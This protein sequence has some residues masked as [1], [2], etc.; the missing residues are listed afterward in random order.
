MFSRANRVSENSVA[1]HVYLSMPTKKKDIIQ[2]LEQPYPAFLEQLHADPGTAIAEFERCARA[3]LSAHPSASMRSLTAAEQQDV[4]DETI[5]RCKAK[6]G[7]PLRNYS[8][9]WGSF[10]TWL[11]S[12]AESTCNS[13]FPKRTPRPEA[14]P[15]EEGR[16]A[17]PGAGTGDGS[18]RT[19]PAPPAEKKPPAASPPRGSSP[20]PERPGPTQNTVFAWLRSPR[21]LILITIVAVIVAFRALQSSRDTSPGT[22][23]TTGPIDIALLGDPESRAPQY[24]VLELNN[25]TAAEFDQGR[26]PVTAV[27]RSGRLT[28]LR[29]A[30]GDLPES[31]SPSRLVVEN[32]AG[33]IA[34]DAPIDPESF[35]GGALN[36]RIDPKT[37]VPDEYVIRVLG[38]SDAILLRSAFSIVV[39]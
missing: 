29:L 13:K 20:S 22:S 4:I 36:L 38:T 32:K 28:V 24:D 21:V 16:S 15:S 14:P 11:T 19:V 6:D 8:D 39:Q 12:V 37:I 30:T 23:V 1:P 5:T 33:E 27:F 7:E 25:I 17:T 2:V 3:W 26:I 9:M 31:S 34:W 18:A 35:S 10:G